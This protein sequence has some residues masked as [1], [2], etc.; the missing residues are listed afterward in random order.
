[1]GSQLYGCVGRLTRWP[2]VVEY[3]D[4]ASFFAKL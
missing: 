4:S 2:T 1:M 3:G